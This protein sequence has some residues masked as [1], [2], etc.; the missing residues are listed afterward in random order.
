MAERFQRTQ[1]R[2]S[3]TGRPYSD[4]ARNQRMIELY[5]DGATSPEIGKVFGL[6]GK[7]VMQVL[8]AYGLTGQDGGRVA[9]KRLRESLD[10]V[11]KP[12]RIAR[13]RV[14]RRAKKLG[15][16]LADFDSNEQFTE[17]ADRFKQQKSR[18]VT[19]KVPWELTLS[20]WWAIWRDSGQWAMRGRS[21]AGSAVMSRRGDQGAY[22]VGNVRISTLAQ[23]FTESHFVRGHRIRSEL[24]TDPVSFRSPRAEM[25]RDGNSTCGVVR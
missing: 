20:Q 12:A 1:P 3:A 11:D 10:A 8:T 16:S 2:K 21:E 15:V 9:R 23:N 5:R 18:A 19:R 14:E 13:E 4:E 7:G 22:A 17:A 6:T 24:V 25:A